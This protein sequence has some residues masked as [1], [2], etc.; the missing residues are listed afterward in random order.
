MKENHCYNNNT[1]R[2]EYTN[3]INE[4]NQYF[5]EQAQKPIYSIDLLYVSSWMN[6]P[7]N[8]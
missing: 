4:S 5:G 6:N 7:K 2:N 8:K 1:P 3:L